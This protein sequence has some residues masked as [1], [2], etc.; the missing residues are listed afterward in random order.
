MSLITTLLRN[1]EASAEVDPWEFPGGFGSRIYGQIE[2]H[3]VH[4]CCSS[5]CLQSFK[6]QPAAHGCLCLW[7]ALWDRLR[8]WSM[9]I[10]RAPCHYAINLSFSCV[11]RGCWL[12]IAT[13]SV[14][15]MTC[16]WV[17]DKGKKGKIVLAFGS[18]SNIFGTS[19]CNIA[20]RDS[21]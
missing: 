20:F 6:G 17:K 3:G 5:Q 4:S 7:T 15:D 13:A 11:S 2:D 1:K 8:G 18:S 9:G 21:L 12:M 14:T 16:C 19:Q 10:E